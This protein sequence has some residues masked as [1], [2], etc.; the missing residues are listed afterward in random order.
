MSS[1]AKREVKFVDDDPT[2]PNPW[3]GRV[4]PAIGPNGDLVIRFCDTDV[5]GWQDAKAGQCPI[6]LNSG[7]PAIHPDFA[8][9]GFV[10]YEDLC[11]G[12]VPGV[13]ASLEHWGYWQRLAELRRSGREPAPGSI[14]A[15][16]FYH[17]EVLRRR[18]RASQGGGLNSM[19]ANEVA[20]FLGFAKAEP[21][22]AFSA[23]FGEP[24]DGISDDV[25]LP[26]PV[27]ATGVID[28]AHAHVIDEAHAHVI[29]EALPAA[30]P[31][32]Q[33]KGQG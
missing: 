3:E 2:R 4:F 8:R 28:E 10:L 32:S 21:I 15:E 1:K 26:S 13:E 30:S 5:A 33:R 17:P 27:V 16:K 12:R 24:A 23:V 9:R 29:D 11:R 25:R 6:T 19:D 20:A 7:Q 31:S 14:P 18:E 22:D